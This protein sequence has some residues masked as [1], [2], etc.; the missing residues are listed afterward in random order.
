MSGVCL[1]VC[2]KKC[3]WYGRMGCDEAVWQGKQ[4]KSMLYTR[5]K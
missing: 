1:S 2:G 3:E 4:I 5:E